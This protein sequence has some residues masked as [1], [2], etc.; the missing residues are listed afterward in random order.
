M[1]IKDLVKK[2]DKDKESRLDKAKE[3][4]AFFC[5]Y[6]L[7]E[8]FTLPFAPYQKDIIKLINTQKLYAKDT[9]ALKQY[10]D[11]S[12]HKYLKPTRKIEGILDIEPRDH[13]KTTRMSQALPLWIVLTKQ[14]VF[15][16]VIGASKDAAVNFIDSIKMELEN[17]EK[18]IED[19]GFLK[20][21][22]WKKNKIVLTNGNALAALGAGEA[23]RGIKDRYRRP[24]HIICDDLLKDENVESRTLREYLYRWFKRVV[25]NLGKGALIVVVNTIMHPD[26]LPSRLLGEIESQKLKNWVG[27]RLSAVCPNGKPLWSARWSIADLNKKKEQLGSY[28]YATEWENKP[29]AD[30]DKKFKKEWFK[31]FELTDLDIAQSKK[32]MAVDPA[33]GKETGDFSAICTIGYEKTGLIYTLDAYGKKISDMQ[34]VDVII[35]KYLLWR[36]EKIVFEDQ[37]FQEIYKNML[38]REALKR[39]IVLP[40]VGIKQKGNKQFRISKLSG[41]VEAGIILFRKNQKMLFD[42]L[43]DFPKGHDDLPDALEMAVSEVIGTKSYPVKYESISRRIYRKKKRGLW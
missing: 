23:I 39:G 13:G 29:I 7:K 34:F 5:R 1:I 24:T 35:E 40:V 26:D 19:F 41:L 9:K 21:R 4:F 30:E 18:I 25:M 8:A 32:I 37:V 16:V 2:S 15:P 27:I 28:I 33:T 43:E 36:P 10:I 14:E 6:Y 12:N 20:G 11:F 17:N 31:F 38:I 22:I 42:Q 3:D